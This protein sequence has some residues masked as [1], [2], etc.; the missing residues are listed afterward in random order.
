V[1][2]LHDDGLVA[3][4]ENGSLIDGAHGTDSLS[5]HEPRTLRS[6]PISNPLG[7]TTIP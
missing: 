7:A 2:P 1:V 5:T 4:S 6:S 3:L